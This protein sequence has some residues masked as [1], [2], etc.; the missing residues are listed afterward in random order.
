LSS[1]QKKHNNITLQKKGMVD[2]QL[3]SDEQSQLFSFRDVL[4]EQGLSIELSVPELTLETVVDDK[5]SFLD[6][7]N[8]DLGV[9]MN[10][11]QS[12]FDNTLDQEVDMIKLLKKISNEKPIPIA[13]MQYLSGYFINLDGN[14]LMKKPEWVDFLDSEIKDLEGLNLLCRYKKV[15]DNNSNMPLL[16][17]YFIIGD[18]EQKQGGNNNIE[19]VNLKEDLLPLTTLQQ[20]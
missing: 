10:E 11:Q 9:V 18:G 7:K 16:N 17:K 3:S 14:N 8:I 15:E 1:V 2:E 6:N 5:K 4:N 13:K 20:K 19:I 12:I